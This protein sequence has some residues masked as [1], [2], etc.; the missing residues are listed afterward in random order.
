M[1]KNKNNFKKN[2]LKVKKIKKIKK[3]KRLIFWIMG[4]LQVNGYII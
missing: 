2:S 3:I 4:V 1:K